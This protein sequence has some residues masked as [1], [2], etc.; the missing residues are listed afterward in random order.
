MT[1]ITTTV[2]IVRRWGAMIFVLAGIGGLFA[3]NSLLIYEKL[4]QVD[5]EYLAK[6][7]DV[8]ISSSS[9]QTKRHLKAADSGLHQR[10]SSQQHEHIKQK[11]NHIRSIDNGDKTEKMTMRQLFEQAHP[12]T[13]TNRILDFVHSLRNADLD[14]QQRSDLPYDIYD[15]P[16][17]P[18]ENYPVA[19]NALDVL[20]HWNVDDTSVPS[21]PIYQGL[22]VFDWTTERKKAEAYRLKE[23]PF[24]IKNHPGVMATAERFNSP[25]Y[26]DKL[27]GDETQ[28]IEHGNSNHLMFWRTIS[29]AQQKEAQ[30]TLPPSWRPPTDFQELN[31]AQWLEKA[32]TLEE[33]EKDHTKEE[34]WYFRVNAFR[35]VNK[36]LYDEMPYFDPDRHEYF[37]TQDHPNAFLTVDAD[38]HRG[39]NCRFGMRGLIA[40]MHFD[41]TRN[42]VVLL[43]GQRRYILAHPSQ[44][45]A[46]DLYDRFHPSGRHSKVNWSDPQATTEE[47]KEA[48]LSS[49]MVNEV[50]LQAGDLLYLPTSWFHFIVSLNIVSIRDASFVLSFISDFCDPSTFSLFSP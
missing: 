31:Y 12:A 44:C 28:R 33:P 3:I 49:A 48:P 5:D 42:F 18:P 43:G 46:L 11:Q 9:A 20:D 26:L 10:F 16:E 21:S 6:R 13:D 45:K 8:W 50:V 41:S 24:I 27:L 32:K 15:C 39:I 30:M 34:H 37:E 38:Q 7:P 1:K 23:L 40:E 47:G 17:T 4:T 2:K 29:P 35:Q 36:Y 14:K 19:W 22:C 25:G